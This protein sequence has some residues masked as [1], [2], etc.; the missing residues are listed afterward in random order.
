MNKECVHPSN[1]LLPYA[2]DDDSIRD[3]IKQKSNMNK[4]TKNTTTDF[5]SS[6]KKCF[7]QSS[8]NIQ[9]Y[10][11]GYNINIISIINILKI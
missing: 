1:F 2:I 8:E 3:C 10:T 9:F 6:E 7:F 11:N 4:K 5:L